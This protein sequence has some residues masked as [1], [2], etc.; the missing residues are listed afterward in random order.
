MNQEEYF[1]LNG[2][3]VGFSKRTD[4]RVRCGR[5]QVSLNTPPIR[6]TQT[7]H[8]GLLEHCWQPIPDFFMAN[9]LTVAA[10][11]DL[12]LPN[13]VYGHTF[14]F[15][16]RDASKY[17]QKLHV[18]GSQHSPDFFGTITVDEGWLT[19]KG[20]VSYEDEWPDPKYAMPIEVCKRFD[21]RPLIPPRKKLSLKQALKLPPDQ[22]YWLAIENTESVKTFPEE[23][24]S[25]KNLEDLWLSCSFG[26]KPVPL[27]EALFEL[28]NLH[29]LNLQWAGFTIGALSPDIAKLTKLETL[30][31][32]SNNITELP[33]SIAAL[34]RLELLDVSYNAL[35]TLPDCIGSLPA[36][37][38]LEA[39]GNHFQSL[40]KTLVNIPAVRVNHAYRSLFRDVSYITKHNVP[41]DAAQFTLASK[42]Q[43]F[44]TTKKLLDERSNDEELKACLLEQSTDAVYAK[45]TNADHAVALGASKT[46]GAPHLPIGFAHPC[47]A[48]GL[49]PT[50][51]AQINLNEIAHLQ[52][53]L[54]RTG[55]LYFFLDDFRYGEGP[56]VIH[57]NVEA[58]DLVAHEYTELTR[59][60]DSDVSTFDYDGSSALAR[61]SLLQFSAGP[62]LPYVYRATGT[63]FPKLAVLF[64]SKQSADRIRREQFDG[65]LDSTREALK[66]VA[67][68]PKETTHS[69]NAL[70]WSDDDTSQEQAANAKGG[71]ADEW[72]NLLTLESVDDYC[73]GDAG[74]ITFCIHMKDLAMADFS[75]VVCTVG[76]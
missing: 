60:F 48:N 13:G 7:L 74:S 50:F 64:D 14:T 68:M 31:L 44:A 55:M 63:R 70:I 34:T 65:A 24:L 2:V 4:V 59:W 6:L 30:R 41:V 3:D 66:K 49:L 75:N 11:E 61:E 8:G 28:K 15:P 52:T 58:S 10:F 23:I 71:F 35:Q 32:T 42:P 46:G 1:R 40:P 21:A 57:A 54:P 29:T 37:R 53:W 47:D 18:Y 62:S 17:L 69:L 25:F 72:I 16:Y 12:A 76:H 26:A 5:V 9:G 73:F 38:R 51:Y 27:P 67:L 39:E 36:L 33:Q 45:A 19:V 22:V 43:L 20:V 56:C